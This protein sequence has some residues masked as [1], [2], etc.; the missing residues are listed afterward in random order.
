[1]VSLKYV[2]P[3]RNLGSC[4]KQ[5]PQQDH[6]VRDLPTSLC[7]WQPPPPP[8]PPFSSRCAALASDLPSLL[9]S[10][11]A[12]GRSAFVLGDLGRLRA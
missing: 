9:P 12:R 5:K 11:H 3:F 4:I 2:G 6:E 7:T 8:P 10:S 1:M